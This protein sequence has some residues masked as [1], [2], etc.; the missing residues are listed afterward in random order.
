VTEPHTQA[1]MSPQEAERMAEADV[2]EKA[3]SIAEADA[4]QVARDP[5]DP[6]AKAAGLA[7]A[8]A[9]EKEEAEEQQRL[10]DEANAE[11]ATRRAQTP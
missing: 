7:R 10:Y 1:V 9:R 6:A 4:E 5:R 3:K 2:I 11:R 8:R